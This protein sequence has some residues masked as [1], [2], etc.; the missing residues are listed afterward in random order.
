[1]AS[2]K[3]IHPISPSPLHQNLNMLLFS[4]TSQKSI[5]TCTTYFHLYYQYVVAPPTN[6]QTMSHFMQP[7]IET[8]PSCICYSNYF[9]QLLEFLPPLPGACLP[10]LQ[11]ALSQLLHTI[12]SLAMKQIKLILILLHLK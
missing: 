3:S 1:M 2:Q 4:T 9:I 8:F 7:L 10:H 12:S 11:L 6:S 5:Y